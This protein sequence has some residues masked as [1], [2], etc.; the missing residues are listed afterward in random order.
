MRRMSSVAVSRRLEFPRSGNPRRRGGGRCS[1]EQYFSVTN[2]ANERLALRST[3]M[4]VHSGD[5]D[6]AEAL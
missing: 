6:E 2:S 5:F 1:R 3:G 4:S